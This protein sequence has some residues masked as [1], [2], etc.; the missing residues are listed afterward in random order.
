MD[1]YITP[2]EYDIAEKNGVDPQNLERRIRSL[3]WSKQKAMSTPLRKL[4]NRKK[5]VEIAEANGISYKTFMGRVNTYGW[6]P[7]RAATEPLQDRRKAQKKGVEV[8]RRFPKEMLD[9]AKENNI[10]YH[11]FRARVVNGWD[12]VEAATAPL[13][14]KSES[15]KRAKAETLRK[16][17]DWNR[18]SFK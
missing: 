17:G 14:S 11:T 5:W 8:I 6:T 1:F 18:F 7:E 2:E 16:Y 12:L 10:A 15:G 4:T 9:L 13:V 3:G